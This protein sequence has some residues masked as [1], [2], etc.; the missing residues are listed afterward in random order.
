MDEVAEETGATR[1]QLVYYWLMHSNPQAIP[2]VASTTDEQFEEAM[3]T[4][5][6]ELTEEQMKK[7]TEAKY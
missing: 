3:G 2:L 4:L 1:N 6:L 5:E 7:L